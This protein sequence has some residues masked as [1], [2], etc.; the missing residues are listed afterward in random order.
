MM[1][2][3]LQKISMFGCVEC[4][5]FMLDVIHLEGGKCL[6]YLE[7]YQHLIVAWIIINVVLNY[8]GILFRLRS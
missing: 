6:D 4:Y 2:R 3:L 7:R 1:E 8:Q 5:Y